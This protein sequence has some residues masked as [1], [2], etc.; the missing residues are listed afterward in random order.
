MKDFILLFALRPLKAQGYQNH[1]SFVSVS[2]IQ[3]KETTLTAKFY[4][5][6]ICSGVGVILGPVIP[7]SKTKRGNMLSEIEI[8]QLHNFMKKNHQG[9]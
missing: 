2:K 6:Y 4:Y 7:K 1:F 8:L 3:E 5:T 9:N